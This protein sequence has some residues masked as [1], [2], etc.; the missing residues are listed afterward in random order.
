MKNPQSVETP[1]HFQGE[2]LLL[3]TSSHYDSGSPALLALT[4]NNQVFAKL[5]INPDSPDIPAFGRK[6]GEFI[7]KDYAENTPLTQA[8]QIASIL[9]F[10][11]RFVQVGWCNC[12][13]MTFH[14]DGKT[15]T[16]ETVE[17]NV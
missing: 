2:T 1:F 5:S 11:G 16:Q 6:E 14:P 8:L 9:Q 4:T 13:I 7:I 12:P 10:A 15:N 17:L 3:T